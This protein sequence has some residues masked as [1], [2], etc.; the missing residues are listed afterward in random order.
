[1]KDLIN[2]L[3]QHTAAQRRLQSLVFSYMRY[4]T[5][6]T[7]SRAEAAAMPTKSASDILAGFNT[8]PRRGGCA[9]PPAVKGL[10]D[11]FQHTAAQRRLLQSNSSDAA[12]P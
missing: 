12:S 8:Q 2:A 3:F 1:M 5:V 11:V 6:S 10:A 4:N 7:H 9:V